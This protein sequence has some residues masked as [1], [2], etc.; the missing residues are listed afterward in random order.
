MP[1]I[2]NRTKQMELPAIRKNMAKKKLLNFK[3]PR[4]KKQTPWR[5]SSAAFSDMGEVSR[6]LVM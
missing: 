2:L 4:N 5:Q 3:Y 1:D 6:S